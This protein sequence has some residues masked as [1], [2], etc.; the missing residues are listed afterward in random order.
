VTFFGWLGWIVAAL[1]VGV[2]LGAGVGAKIEQNKRD[3]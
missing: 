1:L 2:F 3:R